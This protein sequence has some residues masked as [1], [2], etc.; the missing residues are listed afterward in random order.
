MMGFTR[1]RLI[2]FVHVLPFP[3]P[4]IPTAP[5]NLDLIPGHQGVFELPRM[6]FQPLR[7]AHE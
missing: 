7:Y 6:V 3:L 5:A 2:I 1:N 4:L